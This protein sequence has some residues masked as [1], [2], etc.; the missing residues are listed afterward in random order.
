MVVEPDERTGTFQQLA[1]T[2]LGFPATKVGWDPSNRDLGGY[3]SAEQVEL[4]ATTGDVLR[5]WDLSKDWEG[6]AGNGSGG[7]VGRNGWS[8]EYV[9]NARS[10]LT[11]VSAA[12][13]LLLSAELGF[14]ASPRK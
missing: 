9:L 11:N 13:S 2:N 7:Y 5:I 1:S 3:D 4:L 10:V 14:R 6:S 8:N 12:S